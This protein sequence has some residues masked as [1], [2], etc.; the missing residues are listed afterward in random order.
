MTSNHAI[1]TKLLE[2]LRRLGVEI[3]TADYDGSGDRGQIEDPQF[4]SREVPAET[5]KAVLDFFYDALEE[6]HPGWEL[7][8]GSYGTFEW[9]VR[10]D[11]I[12]LAHTTITE[13][14]E[15]EVL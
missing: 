14:Y 4:G 10:V 1:R 9:D 3:V 12:K 13:D 6:V 11:A 8:E 2:K 7:N 15:E 5:Q